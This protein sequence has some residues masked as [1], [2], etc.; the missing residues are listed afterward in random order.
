MTTTWNLRIS[1]IHQSEMNNFFQ[2]LI[3][4]E[5]YVNLFRLSVKGALYTFGMPSFG[6]Y[7]QW[8]SIPL[9][10]ISMLAGGLVFIPQINQGKI[11]N[12]IFASWCILVGLVLILAE[13]VLFRFILHN[14]LVRG[15]I[16]AIL[17][18]P[19]FGVS[20]GG[21]PGVLIFV[22]GILYAFC[23]LRYESGG[24]VVEED[25]QP[26]LDETENL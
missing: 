20:L 16:W 3:S 12:Y 13:V 7:L 19:C 2:S 4:P 25:V 26:L 14:Y 6:R 8:F 22:Y 21:A 1:E 5:S 11:E 10:L 9:G 23:W 17:A 18:L 24:D 15:I